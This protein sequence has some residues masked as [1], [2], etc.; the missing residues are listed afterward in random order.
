MDNG[1]FQGSEYWRG[2]G[3]KEQRHEV[4]RDRFQSE[5][6]GEYKTLRGVSWR[7]CEDW[8]WPG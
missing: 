8:R 5:Q 7:L 3:S 6:S 4:E 1:S 2:V